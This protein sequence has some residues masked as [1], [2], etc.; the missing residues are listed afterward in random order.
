[1][2]SGRQIRDFVPVDHVAQLLL[3]LITNPKAQGIYNC[4]SGLPISLRELAEKR[5]IESHA[6]THLTL[7]VYP[8]REDEPLT[9]WADTS[10]IDRLS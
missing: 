8:D 4:G 9:F 7:G 5:I 2:S 10:K 6:S 1:M 3:S